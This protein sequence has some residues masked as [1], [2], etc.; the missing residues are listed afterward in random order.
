MLASKIFRAWRVVATGSAF[1]YFMLGGLVLALIG[2]PLLRLWPGTHE[3]KG[4]RIRRLIQRTFRGFLRYMHFV[5]IMKVPDVKGAEH[6]QNAGGSLIVA[7]H[8]TLIDVVLLVSLIQDCNCVVKRKLWD[9]FFIG[10]VVRG[11]EYIPNDDGPDMMRTCAEGFRQ[12]RPLLIFPEGTR[13]PENGMH[14]FNRSAAQMAL[15]LGVPMVPAVLT[16]APPTLM[17]HQRW[18][19]VPERRFQLTLNVHPPMEIPAEVLEKKELPLQV[20]A[21]TRYM[22]AF[23]RTETDLQRQESTTAGRMVI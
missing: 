7:S 22:E 8:P 10:P 17:K 20:R 19:E 5:G 6:L 13:S 15:R 9:H 16:C 14:P 2:F 18:H 12:G 3:V 21:L 1:A 4:R 23:F 11:A